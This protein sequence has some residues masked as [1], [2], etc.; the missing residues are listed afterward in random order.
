MDHPLP[1][2]KYVDAGDRCPK[3]AEITWNGVSFCSS[4]VASVWRSECNPLCCLDLNSMPAR[5]RQS[6]TILYK[7]SLA[8]KGSKGGLKVRNTSRCRLGGRPAR[9]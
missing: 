4:L 7:W 1:W 5:F 2:L 6:E 9:R 3:T 8:E